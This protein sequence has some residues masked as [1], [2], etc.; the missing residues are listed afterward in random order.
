MNNISVCVS[1]GDRSNKTHLTLRKLEKQ[2]R[3]PFQA[4]LVSLLVGGVAGHIATPTT[5]NIMANRI[6][7]SRLVMG[8]D[9][10]QTD[11]KLAPMVISEI[12]IRDLDKVSR[13]YGSNMMKTLVNPSKFVN[14]NNHNNYD[15]LINTQGG[16]SNDTN[17]K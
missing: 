1:C 6:R 5:N 9:V 13:R 12:R 14:V 16:H 17:T 8:K 7:A 10:S 3:Q 4:F 2:E 15:Y 11:T